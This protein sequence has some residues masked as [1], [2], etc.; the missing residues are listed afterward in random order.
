VIQRIA[1]VLVLC[2][3]PLGAGHAT[4]AYDDWVVNEVTD[5]GCTLGHTTMLSPKEG[6]MV[7]FEFDQG[8][9]QRSKVYVYGL[10]E[11]KAGNL[12]FRV[13]GHTFNTL[14]P[15]VSDDRIATPVRGD[16]ELPNEIFNAMR[17]GKTLRYEYRIPGEEKPF[18]QEV[19][20]DGLDEA[21][22]S[23]HAQGSSGH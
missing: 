23:C 14:H 7:N 18:T 19:S 12:T 9:P 5:G 8:V 13:D 15:D 16:A 17:V 22:A 2:V 6:P 21:V 3:S 11:L 20:L 10:F 4:R 1:L